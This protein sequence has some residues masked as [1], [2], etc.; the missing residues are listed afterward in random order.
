[1]KEQLEG[2]VAAE[3]RTWEISRVPDRPINNARLIGSMIYRTRLELFEAWYQ[4]HGADV[5]RSAAALK[6]LTDGAVGDEAFERLE[7][8]LAEPPG[9]GAP[10]RRTQGAPAGMPGRLRVSQHAD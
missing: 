7:R 2:P 4:R 5:G 3:L 10:C 6:S 8:A 9:N 1:M